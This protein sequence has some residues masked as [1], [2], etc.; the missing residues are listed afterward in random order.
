LQDKVTIWHIPEGDVTK[1]HD[2]T[3]SESVFPNHLSHGN[4]IGHCI[5]AQQ[6]NIT[7]EQPESCTSTEN[8]LIADVRVNL[9]GFPLAQL[10]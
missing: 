7:I 8:G 6:P 10:S 2:L 4:R 1:A 5:L 3:V 9:T